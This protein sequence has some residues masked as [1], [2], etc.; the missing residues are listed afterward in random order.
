MINGAFEF[1][2]QGTG[3]F[4]SDPRGQNP[5]AVLPKFCRN[6]HDLFRPLAG[7]K[8]HFRK[9]FA[10]RA[11]S[12]NLCKAQVGYRRGLEGAQDFFAR[13]CSSAKLFQQL[14]GFG[15]C[16]AVVAALANDF[17]GSIAV[18]T[19]MPAATMAA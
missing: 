8:N 11:M 4:N 19:P 1:F 5:L 7:A 10:E 15:G 12:I 6:L 14:I 2:P 18:V 3:M 17:I 9:I 13:N 16:H